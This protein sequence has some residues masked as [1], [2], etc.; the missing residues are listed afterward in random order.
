MEWVRRWRKG[1]LMGRESREG[2]REKQG[3]GVWLGDKKTAVDVCLP[4]GEQDI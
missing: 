1:Q 2:D 4:G 3:L